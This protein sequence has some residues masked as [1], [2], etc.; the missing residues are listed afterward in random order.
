M[1]YC[2]LILLKGRGMGTCQC[3]TQPHVGTRVSFRPHDLPQSG[4]LWVGDVRNA[5]AVPPEGWTGTDLPALDIHTLW[6]AYLSGDEAAVGTAD[7]TPHP[8]VW[9]ALQRLSA[10][11]SDQE[12]ARR[13]T[14]EEIPSTDTPIAADDTVTSMEEKTDTADTA[15]A[16]EEAAT[17]ASE[18]EKASVDLADMGVT[19]VLA[20]S[21]AEP[22]SGTR[23]D[24]LAARLGEFLSR[25]ARY[26]AFAPLTDAIEG[27]RWVEA[28]PEEGGYL[29]GVLYD[30]TPAPTHLCYGVRG[31]R[32]RPFAADAEW[33]D[34]ER[35]GEGYWIVYQQL[36]EGL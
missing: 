16:P 8:Y 17:M 15:I 32:D 27:S 19:E 12:T 2:N 10:A 6:A 33:L 5:F 36:D 35:E 31:T 23:A 3:K 11:A 34:A 25:M 7:G 28:P 9:D 24:A 20:D 21:D 29:L 1:L 4:S 18:P 30:S 26:P 14:E 22:L 13:N